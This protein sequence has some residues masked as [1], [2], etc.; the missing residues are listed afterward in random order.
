V[1]EASHIRAEF[2]RPVSIQIYILRR[3]AYN[4]GSNNIYLYLQSRNVRA[5]M[6]AAP[7]YLVA[8]RR[9]T[10]CLVIE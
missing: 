2:D 7:W 10:E 8:A 3:D 6:M 1:H 5:N 9:D 4:G